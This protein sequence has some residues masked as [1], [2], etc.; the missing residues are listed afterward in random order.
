MIGNRR[1]RRLA[2]VNAIPT[3]SKI[4]ATGTKAVAVAPVFGSVEPEVVVPAPEELPLPE[5]LTAVVT[6]VDIVVMA[7]GAV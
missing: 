4:A 5:L 1:G 7:N 3:T 2:H 6:G